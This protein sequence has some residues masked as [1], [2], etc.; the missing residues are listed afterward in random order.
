MLHGHLSNK[1][2]LKTSY[3]LSPVLDDIGKMAIVLNFSKILPILSIFTFLI[4][5]YHIRP[6]IPTFLWKKMGTVI[7]RNS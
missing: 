4:N 5:S 1:H 6:Y 7:V 2:L 3:V